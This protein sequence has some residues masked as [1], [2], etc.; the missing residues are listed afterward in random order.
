MCSQFLEAIG[1]NL[2]TWGLLGELYPTRVAGMGAGITTCMANL[3]GFAAIKLYPGFEA[4]LRGNQDRDGGVFFFFGAVAFVGTVFV[5]L[6]LPETFRKSLEEVSEE[7]RHGGN[8]R[9]CC[10]R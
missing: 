9:I 5:Y 3:M 4:L 1:F 7:F 6:L 2:I 8:N 10:G